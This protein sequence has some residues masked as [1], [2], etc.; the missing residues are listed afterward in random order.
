M[1]YQNDAEMLFPDRVIP[2]LRELRGNDWKA[3]VEQVSSQSAS[4]P[5]LLAFGLMM[6]RL[7]ACMSCHSDSY[8]A[9]RGCTNCAQQT[10]AR[11][12]GTDSDL[13]ERWRAAR[14]EIQAYLAEGTAPTID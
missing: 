11:F 10:V 8:R 7:S 4:D 3:L 14:A 12:K 13:I 6:I 9:L 1:L 5:D 2:S